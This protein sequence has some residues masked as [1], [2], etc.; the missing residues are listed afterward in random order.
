[1]YCGFG[2]TVAVTLIVFYILFVAHPIT[3]QFSPAV[4]TMM[5]AATFFYNFRMLDVF[6]LIQ[7]DFPTLVYDVV[8]AW[9]LGSTGISSGSFTCIAPKKS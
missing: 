7:F 4:F 9:S 5:A 3:S 2:L 6:R 1:V 8:D